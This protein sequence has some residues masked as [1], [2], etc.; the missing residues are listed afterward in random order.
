MAGANRSHPAAQQTQRKL[1]EID[2]GA[3]ADAEGAAHVAVDFASRL[4]ALMGGIGDQLRRQLAGV[5]KIL[6]QSLRAAHTRRLFA[7]ANDG[8]GGGV[9]LETPSPLQLQGTPSG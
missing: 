6:F 2:D 9:L 7:F 1:Q 8:G 4:V 5:F 3:E